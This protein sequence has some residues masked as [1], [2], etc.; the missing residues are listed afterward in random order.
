MAC[1]SDL[2]SAGII[3]KD[4]NNDVLWT[5]S[6]PSI[7]TEYKTLIINKCGL[8]NGLGLSHGHHLVSFCYYHHQQSWFYL[9]LTDVF[10]HPTLLKVKQF[11]LV[12]QT[13]DFNPEKYESLSRILS[14]TYSKTGNPAS[15]LQLYLSVLVRGSCSTEDNGT[16]MIKQFDK[17]ATFSCVPAKDVVKIFGLETILIYTALLLKKRIVVYH[18]RLDSL[19]WFVR[20]LPAFMWHRQDWS[21]IYPYMQLT[22][23]EISELLSLQTYIAGFRDA[24]VEGRTELYD[25]FVNLPAIEIT[26]AAHAKEMF[27]M[28]KT[29]KEIAVFMTRQAENMDLNDTLFI[30]EVANKTN[31]LLRSL[32]NLAVRNESGIEVIKL[33]EL[34]EN[35]FAPALENF[36]WNLAAAEGYTHI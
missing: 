1:I 6:Y 29:H 16:F 2:V 4:I 22:N 21:I 25:V 11:V 5:W 18:H 10:D 26:V 36:L 17:I 28:T 32:R 8:G 23:V 27:A 7:S 30:K 20:A 13:R 34:K 12:L 33:S 19:L 3:E 14:K 31:E 9:H 35:K 15:M 24:A